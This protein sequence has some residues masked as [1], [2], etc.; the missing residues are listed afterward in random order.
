MLLKQNPNYLKIYSVQKTLYYALMNIASLKEKP[1]GVDPFGP[2]DDNTAFLRLLGSRRVTEYAT[3]VFTATELSK[4][5][6]FYYYTD[7]TVGGHNEN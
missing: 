1:T 7:V 6:Q 5:K 2:R 3:C 4:A